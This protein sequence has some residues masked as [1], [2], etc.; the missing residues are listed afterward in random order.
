MIRI[1]ARTLLLMLISTLLTGAVTTLVVV[2]L[3]TEGYIYLGI[4]AS[5]GLPLL[6]AWA[7]YAELEGRR[8]DVEGTDL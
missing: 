8:A 4:A 7:T 1:H 2:G 5:I 6:V 3:I